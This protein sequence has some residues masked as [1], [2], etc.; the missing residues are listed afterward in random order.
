MKYHFKNSF[1][2]SIKNL[3][4]KQKE[5]IKQ[6]C[7]EIIDVLEGKRHRKIFCVNFY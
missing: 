6:T 7:I 4:S 1:D 2:K 5:K 3:P